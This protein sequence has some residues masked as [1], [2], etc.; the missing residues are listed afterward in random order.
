MPSDLFPGFR[1]LTQTVRHDWAQDGLDLH[2]RIGG[3]GP[4]LLLVHGY[5]Q[6]GAMWHRIAPS[7]ATRFT[8]VIPDLRG[9]GASAKPATDA[10]HRPYSKRAM[11]ADMAALMTALGFE[12]FSVAGH[13]RGG[14]VTHRLCLDHAARVTRAAVLDIVPTRH[15]FETADRSVALA[16]YHWY[17][18]AQP[19][20]YP[21]TLIGADPS[22]FLLHKLG[23]LSG[24]GADFFDP[25]ALADYE[26]AFHDPA[27]IH[28]SCEDYRAA[29][30]IDLEDDSV[31]IDRRIACPLL[32]LWGA[33]AP[34]HTHYDVLE[35]WR[36]R[37]V[38]LEG[39]PLDCGHFLAEEAPEA[40]LAAFERFFTT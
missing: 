39:H 16:Y 19:A 10:E 40:T 35:T 28:G 37:A 6:T 23:G 29:A 8:V 9:Y 7:L 34:M 27:V 21:E 4:P 26:A 24:A 14:R 20:P 22:Y 5:P 31:D 25:T 12:A 17:F 13:D 30:G 1:I 15:L 18:L 33:R 3:D 32:V 36:E 2:V 38:T 11:A